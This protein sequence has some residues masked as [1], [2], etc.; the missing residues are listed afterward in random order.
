[1]RSGR[2]NHLLICQSTDWYQMAGDHSRSR[3]M[4]ASAIRM[5]ITVNLCESKK[6]ILTFEE[7]FCAHNWQ[8]LSD[9]LSLTAINLC[10]MPGGPREW[11]KDWKICPHADHLFNTWGELVEWI[12]S[13]SIWSEV[14]SFPAA[15]NT[16]GTATNT[17]LMRSLFPTQALCVLVKYVCIIMLP[18]DFYL[19]PF[20]T[21][22]STTTVA[23]QI[24]LPYME[25][26]FL[27]ILLFAAL[28]LLVTVFPLGIQS[29]PVP[30]DVIPCTHIS[31]CRG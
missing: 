20:S 12:I 17:V 15:A 18:L 2:T 28:P 8:I 7:G 1:M 14:Q 3:S 24:S 23:P 13:R 4:A 27:Q 31:L 19:R 25:M 26:L 29:L 30:N 21:H 22:F 5:S 11:Q 6:T 9:F 10:W 16:W